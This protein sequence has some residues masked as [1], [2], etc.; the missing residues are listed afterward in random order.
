[1]DTLYTILV[2]SHSGFR[3]LLLITLLASITLSFDKGFVRKKSNQKKA[4]GL[5]LTTL[6]FSHFQLIFG[7]VLYFVSPKVI[8]SAS[9]MKESYYRF[10]LVEH[11]AMMIIAIA[12]VTIGYSKSKPF[13]SQA[14]GQK[15]VFYYYGIALILIVLA[16]P[17][18]WQPYGTG[19]F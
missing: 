13:L 3:W 5:Y 11:I 19:W 10:F 17:W 15:R 18:P 1:M 2:S 8:F 7:F 16:I 6:I 9:S 14:K 4:K 12:L